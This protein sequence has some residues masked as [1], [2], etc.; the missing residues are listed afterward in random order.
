MKCSATV[1]LPGN[2]QNKLLHCSSNGNNVGTTH[3]GIS[4][5]LSSE[6]TNK[7]TAQSSI[8]SSVGSLS[9]SIAHILA[10]FFL[11]SSIKVQSF[12]HSGH[13]HL[14]SIT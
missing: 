9:S 8:V 12:E 10:L 11:V 13:L 1:V 4:Y 3:E 5:S 6:F 14:E 7:G 2:P